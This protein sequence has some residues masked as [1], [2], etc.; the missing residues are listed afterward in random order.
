M[1]PL[2]KSP[3]SSI[4]TTAALAI[5]VFVYVHYTALR[6]NGPIGYLKH[7]AGSPKSGIE[8]AFA[9]SCSSIHVVGEIA[10]P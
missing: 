7:L 10:R 5:C 2:G 4:N 9:P 6:R 3:T 1:I 8:W